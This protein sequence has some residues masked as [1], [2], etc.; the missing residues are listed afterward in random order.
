M[1][2]PNADVPHVID[3]ASSALLF[4]TESESD[5]SMMQA[6]PVLAV[7]VDGI[8]VTESEVSELSSDT[9]SSSGA[10]RGFR[11]WRQ[12]QAVDEAAAFRAWS[13]AEEDSWRVAILAMRAAHREWVAEMSVQ[14]P[15]GDDM[16][17]ALEEFSI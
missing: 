8:D 16:D 6:D 4:D 15:L 9:D 1:A 5:L 14:P 12:E 3:D 7:M 13:R 17:N 11:E 2:D 10:F